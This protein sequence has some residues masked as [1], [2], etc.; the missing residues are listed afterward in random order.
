MELTQ[1]TTQYYFIC[2]KCSKTVKIPY[3]SHGNWQVFPAKVSCPEC[4]K[5]ISKPFFQAL[6]LK[7]F[8]YKRSRSVGMVENKKVPEI[9]T[10]E[11][12]AVDTE[13][14]TFREA[15]KRLK[16]KE[17][18]FVLEYVKDF[19]GSR[20]AT[21]AGYS[22]RTA[23][24]KASELLTI[25]NIQITLAAFFNERRKTAKKTV[26]D[27]EHFLE[28]VIFTPITEILTFTRDG[29]SFVKDSDEMSEDAKMILEGVEF[30][31]NLSGINVKVRM[32][33]KL[34]AAKLLGQQKGMFRQKIDVNVKRETYEQWRIRVGMDKEE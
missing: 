15:L 20:A 25:V 2:P 28:T 1:G 7:G 17:Q 30:S 24:I 5:D 33:N 26:D 4:K 23:R 12:P 34:K 27:I 21:V 32:C 18:M 16:Y 8:K 22:Q 29:L 9:G 19:N 6:L 10:A 31:E 14:L 11:N 13:T 3:E